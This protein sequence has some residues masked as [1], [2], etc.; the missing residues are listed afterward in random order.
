MPDEV[1]FDPNRFK[2]FL[3]VRSVVKETE[4]EAK[5]SGLAPDK[6]SRRLA[7]LTAEKQQQKLEEAE[8]LAEIDPLTGLLN[9]RGMERKIEEEIARAKRE[10]PK[11][12]FAVFFMDLNNLGQINNLSEDQHTAGDIVL[13][14]LANILTHGARPGDIIARVGGDEFVVILESTNIDG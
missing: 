11:R 9:R 14:A 3:K 6:I 5:Q 10:D 2:R 12:N 13:K 8:G 4:K 7:L 1:K